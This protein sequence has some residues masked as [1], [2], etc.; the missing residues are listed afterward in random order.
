MQMKRIMKTGDDNMGIKLGYYPILDEALC[1][2]QIYS[3]ERF[4]PYS[5]ALEWVDGRLS[6]SERESIMNMGE[7][8]GGWL[9][10]I[11][12]GI[13]LVTDGVSTFEE[14]MVK[15]IHEPSLIFEEGTK[16]MADRFLSMW[17]NHCSLQKTKHDKEI[18]DK[19]MEISQY[20]NK[21][22]L[23]EYLLSLSDRIKRVN[24]EIVFN[25]KPDH[26]VS[27]EDIDNIIVMPS[28]FA[29]RNLIFWY[30]GNTYLF[31]VSLGSRK[32]SL[33]EPSDMLLLRTLAFNDKTRLKMLRALEQS[34]MSVNDMAEKLKINP[35]T[36]SRHFKVFK[37]TGFVD[38]QKQEGNSIYY[39]LKEGEIKKAFQMISNYI[40][41]GEVVDD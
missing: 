20:Q 4:K 15:I 10:A 14:S 38:I 23:I 5:E 33:E 35:S 17:W 32:M 19:L 37:D 3:V 31:Y 1:M 30:S 34:S 40:F 24:D 7:K 39:G 16:E 9:S 21:E 13:D 6:E 22:E 28:V 18:S 26:R 2:R 27:I 29:S 36:V 12:S 41:K 8:S 25:I 11:S